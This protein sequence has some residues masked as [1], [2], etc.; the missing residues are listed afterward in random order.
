MKDDRLLIRWFLT[1]SLIGL[2]ACGRGGDSAEA[3]GEVVR[4]VIYHQVA[5]VS[6]EFTRAFPARVAAADMRELNFPV[7]GMVLPVPVNESDVVREGQLLAQLDARDYASALSAARARVD[8]AVQALDRA[9]RLFEQDAVSKSV[10]EQREAAAGVARAEF[11]AAEKALADTRIEAPFDGIVSRVFVRE[12][13]TVAPGT[14][15]VRVFSKEAL[16]ATI[17][18]PASLIVNA[19]GSRKEQG[20]ALVALD[21]DPDQPIEAIFKKADLEADAS[22]QSYAVTFA[23][24]APENLNELPGMNAELTLTLHGRNAPVRGVEVPIRAIAAQG[25]ARFVWVID[26]G[27]EPHRVERLTVTV[28]PAVGEVLPILS[29]LEPGETVVAAGLSELVEGMAV[30][31]WSRDSN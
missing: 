24:A 14:P 22:S 27:V 11:E 25:E 5:G 9:K 20:R 1:F 3:G 26:T 2:S 30:R 21:A 18:V 12:S 6:G 16:E 29:G 17:A 19:D 7:G 8:N 10:L 23:F 13:Q 15:A 4:P 31:P 28:G